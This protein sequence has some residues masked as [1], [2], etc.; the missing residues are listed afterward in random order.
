MEETARGR[1]A[2]FHYNSNPFIHGAALKCVN[3]LA[4][5][6]YD[7]V[8]T[9][10]APRKEAVAQRGD[11]TRQQLHARVTLRQVALA[12]RRLPRFTLQ[13]LKF[14]EMF[15]RFA[16]RAFREPCHCVMGF[17][18]PA[19]LPAYVGARLAGKPVLYFALE[20][21]PEQHWVAGRAFWRMASRFLCPRVDALVV[22]DSNRSAY[23][24][25]HYRARSPVAIRNTPAFRPVERTDT[26][27][28]TLAGRGIETSKIAL[29]QGQVE[30][31]RGVEQMIDMVP[32]LREDTAVVILGGA[33]AEY[34]EQLRNRI[35]AQGLENRILMLP[36][37]L[38]AEVWDYTASAHCGLI[39]HQP[40]SLNFY[41]N[42]GATNKFYE[43][44]MAGIPVVTPNFP[45]F[46]EVVEAEKVGLCVDPA[47]PEAIAAA[48]NSILADEEEWNRMRERALKLA[49]E[50]F[51]WGI[52]GARFV[53]VVDALMRGA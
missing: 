18:P 3:T 19:V 47:S 48:V 35:A 1:I 15:V 10:P 8:L 30:P 46:P 33:E 24:V 34:S 53:E 52:D 22:V 45:G 36:P 27:Q 2:V 31:A 5:A 32:Y 29:Y 6:G 49:Q 41:Y 25:E 7:V 9:K 21:Y 38:P 14:L 50:R 39:A 17:D 12:T 16:W 20:L 44:L 23:M 11:R 4:E 51:N 42:A 28:R 26:L 43:Y 40:V 37:V 13:F